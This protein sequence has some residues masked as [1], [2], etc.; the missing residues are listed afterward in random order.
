MPKKFDRQVRQRCVRQ[1]AEH[2][3]ERSSLTAPA[4][5]VVAQRAELGKETMRRWVTEAQVEGGERQGATSEGL[6]EIMDLKT[7]VRRVEEDNEMLRRASIFFAGQARLP[8][9]LIVASIDE[10]RSEGHTV[11]SILVVAA[12]SCASRLP[13]R[14]TDLPHLG[15]HPPAGRGPNH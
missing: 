9:P 12:G 14:C 13:D 15:Q 5:E 6:A 2:L 4:A 11:E 3:S 1:V 8:Q 10:M 7:K